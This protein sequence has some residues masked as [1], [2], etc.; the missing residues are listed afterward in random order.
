[1][2]ADG[3]RFLLLT[4]GYAWELAL[5]LSAIPPTKELQRGRDYELIRLQPILG[6]ETLTYLP[7]DRSFLY[8]KEFKPDSK[9]SEL[10]RMVCLD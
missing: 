5:D 10:I 4:Y 1:M 7:G 9:P 3:S 6:K 8:G 2:S